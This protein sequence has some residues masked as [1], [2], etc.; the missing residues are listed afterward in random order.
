MRLFLIISHLEYTWN[1]VSNEL[2][3]LRSKGHGEVHKQHEIAISHV[4]RIVHVL[5]GGY[6][7]RHQLTQILDT[8]CQ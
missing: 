3:E 5:T 4:R 8:T 2:D 7:L 1:H 6:E